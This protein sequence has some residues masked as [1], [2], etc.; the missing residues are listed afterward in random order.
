MTVYRFEQGL[1]L[2][3]LFVMVR[4]IFAIA[5]PVQKR[6]GCPLICH[7]SPVFTGHLSPCSDGYINLPYSAHD[8]Y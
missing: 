1:I 4:S 7:Q 2:C 5:A 3:F 6:D 8:V